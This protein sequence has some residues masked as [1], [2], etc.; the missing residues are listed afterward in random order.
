MQLR[1]LMTQEVEISCPDATLQEAAQRMR[2]SSIGAV[3]GALEVDTI[4]HVYRHFSLDTPIGEEGETS[5]LDLLPSATSP[6]GD[7]AYINA[8]LRQEIQELL[9]QLPPPE[10]QILRL[11]FGL[12][13]EAKT[14]EEI[15]GMLGLTRERVRQIEKQAKDRL[16]QRAKMRALQEYLN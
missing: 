9:S 7:E 13:G 11:R 5:F 14:L 12:D 8:T 6:L 16:R 15:G 1:E 2:A 3:P 4:L 10:Q